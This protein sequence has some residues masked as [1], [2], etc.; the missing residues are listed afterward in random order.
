MG[1]FWRFKLAWFEMYFFYFRPLWNFGVLPKLLFGRPDRCQI[2]GL[3]TKEIVA[4][5]RSKSKD[6]NRCQGL[7]PP[8]SSPP[9]R[10]YANQDLFLVFPLCLCAPPSCRLESDK[11]VEEALAAKGK[12]QQLIISKVRRH[13]FPL[14]IHGYSVT[15]TLAHADMNFVTDARALSVQILPPWGK[16]RL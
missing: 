7:H 12:Q 5:L 1:F 4:T 9:E 10:K 14:H 2:S 3:R 15:D 13:R 8:H 6:R 11:A 16:I